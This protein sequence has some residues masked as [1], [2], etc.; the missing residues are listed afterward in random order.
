MSITKEQI[1]EAL[2]HVWYPEVN[3]DLVELNMIASVKIEGN[4]VSIVVELPHKTNPFKNSIVKA[5]NEVLGVYVS[6]DLKV[7]VDF[8]YKTAPKQEVAENAQLAGAKNIIAIASGKGGVGKSTVATNLAVALAKAGASVG[9]IDADVYGPSLP[10][11]FNVED[12]R[13]EMR[14][15][16]D[17]DYIVPVTKYGVKMLSIGFFVD[18][19]S[20]LIWRGP[21]ATSAL[22]QLLFETLWGTLDYLLIDLPPG[23]SDIHL[24]LVQSV[25][26]SG[27]V[28]VSTPQN[29]ALADAQ[30]GI[31][32][33][34][35]DKINVP[36]LGMVENMAWFTPQELPDNKYY[37]FGKDGC[38][39]LA[40]ELNLP[41]LGQIPIVQS[42]CE[43]GDNGTP[44][45]L[46][47]DTIV[48]QAFKQ[49][50]AN[51]IE[52][53]NERNNLAPTKIVEV[54]KTAHKH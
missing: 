53:M 3:K 54:H 18:P 41:L 24:T 10:K 11:M 17:K 8:T 1:I 51:V 36:I 48:G 21:M 49:L 22:K 15:I 38:K 14:Q 2:K 4:T 23:T 16:M 43:D 47:E 12:E 25:S 26:V 45:A 27:A 32:M 28:I 7:N 34:Q 13:P 50:A 9:L 52:K 35:S 6:K 20:A 42:I 40:A 29:V 19:K 30:K 5:C 39:K 46:N 37:I 33:F 31:N 44:S